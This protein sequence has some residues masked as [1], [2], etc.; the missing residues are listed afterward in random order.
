MDL[1]LTLAMRNHHD[2]NVL[3]YRIDA[4]KGIWFLARPRAP[5]SLSF[6]VSKSVSCLWPGAWGG[7]KDWT[8]QRVLFM[9]I[10]AIRFGPKWPLLTEFLLALAARSC[11]WR[12]ASRCYLWFH[13]GVSTF[14]QP[15]QSHH[16]S[17]DKGEK[18]QRTGYHSNADCA[19]AG[20][21]CPPCPALGRSVFWNNLAVPTQLGVAS[22]N[23]P[24]KLWLMSQVSRRD[25]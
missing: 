20:T 24:P 1:F 9:N 17:D 13:S 18:S 22:Q 5:S 8:S 12:V 19:G 4:S 21:A 25:L 6:L 23:C 16:S 2:L 14:Y 7:R 10:S 3:S 15:G 11:R